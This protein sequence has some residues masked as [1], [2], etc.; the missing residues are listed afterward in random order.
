MC[1]SLALAKQ[2]RNYAIRVVDYS[3]DN[4]K[5]YAM[6]QWIYII[7]R[8]VLDFFLSFGTN[9]EKIT[10]FPSENVE[11]KK[12][13]AVERTNSTSILTESIL[14]EDKD[15]EIVERTSST[16]I[17]TDGKES[18]ITKFEGLLKERDPNSQN[19]SLNSILSDIS[20]GKNEACEEF[21]ARYCQEMMTVYYVKK[22]QYSIPKSA[23]FKIC[24]DESSG[25]QIPVVLLPKLR[26]KDPFR[27]VGIFSH[28]DQKLVTL[29]WDAVRWSFVIPTT[30]SKDSGKTRFFPS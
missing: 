9:E 16:S 24:Y 21:L 22:N 29:E 2:G 19:F 10:Q 25:N 12:K 5:H 26:R 6:F 7:I 1:F 27:G 8:E 30:N 11:E 17:L 23:G 4:P 18:E 28:K 13:P 3:D 15:S 14:T 20:E